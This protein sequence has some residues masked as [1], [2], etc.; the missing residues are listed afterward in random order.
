MERFR[1]GDRISINHKGVKEEQTYTILDILEDYGGNSYWLKAETGKMVL[2][3]ET[4]ET[5]FEKVDSVIK[6]TI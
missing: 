5:A 6:T 4:P 1:I 2:A 3:S